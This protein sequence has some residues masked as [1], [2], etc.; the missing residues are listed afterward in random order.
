MVTVNVKC[1]HC[2]KSLMDKKRLIDS[3]PSI[4][5]KLT[6]AGKRAMLYL[7]SVYGSYKVETEIDVP[8][9]KIAGFRC[10]HCDADLKSTRKCD[11]C[12]AQMV[13]FDLK[14]GGQVQICSRRGCKK[15]IVEFE[16]PKTELEAFY[17]S[18]IKAYGD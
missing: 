4:A 18:Y 5:V 17:K 11:I 8:K 12:N 3:K 15:H 2:G 14:E 6:Y 7:S 16:N 1:P 13:A 10:P 9:S